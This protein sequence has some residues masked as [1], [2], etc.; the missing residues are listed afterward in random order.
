MI[1][2]FTAMNQKKEFKSCSFHLDKIESCLDFLNLLAHRGEA[3][4]SAHLI[5]EFGIIEIPLEAFDGNS[6]AN[7]MQQLEHEWQQILSKPVELP[8][9]C[10]HWLQD[11]INQLV[12]KDKLYVT[13]LE[14]IIDR[15]KQKLQQVQSGDFIEP[16]R[17]K[18]LNQYQ[19]SLRFYQQHLA[20]RQSRQ[21]AVLNKLLRLQH[22]ISSPI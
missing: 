4:V 14:E 1:L 9:V 3:I 11:L 15:I 12:S 19:A 18:L 22:N 5:D 2:L 16:Y 10:T 7:P 20:K 13:Y 6:F 8:A 17:S 21:K